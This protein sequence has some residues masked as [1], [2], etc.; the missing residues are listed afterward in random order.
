MAIR[1]FKQVEDIVKKYSLLL[2]EAGLPV[3]KVVLFGSY[4]KN[5]QT[6]SSDI[7]IAVVLKKFIEDRF[8][9]RVKLMKYSRNFEVVIEPHPFLEEEFNDS[10]PFIWE[11]QKNGIVIT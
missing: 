7:D 2:S 3:E 8:T 1:T 11:I 9:T 5:M 10:N 6:E 4:A